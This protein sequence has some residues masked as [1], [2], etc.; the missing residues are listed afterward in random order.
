MAGVWR[1][2]GGGG[3]GRLRQSAL[4]TNGRARQASPHA[5]APGTPFGPGAWRRCCTRFCPFGRDPGSGRSRITAQSRRGHIR[6]QFGRGFVRQWQKH[7]R[8]GPFGRNHA[9][10]RYH[11]L[12]VADSESGRFARRGACQVR[13][14]PGGWPPFGANED[15]SGHRGHGPAQRR[16][17]HIPAWQHGCRRARIQRGACCVSARAHRRA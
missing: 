11:R 4:R 6:R 8:T 10:G 7:G 5:R 12:D 1:N 14:H 3:F 9:R 13:E 15:S 16:V 2:A 17:H